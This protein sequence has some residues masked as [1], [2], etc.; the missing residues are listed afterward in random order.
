MEHHNTDHTDIIEFFDRYQ[1]ALLARDEQ[2]IAQMYAVPS[3]ILFPGQAIPV[4]DAEQTEAF[5]ASNWEQYEGLD[6]VERE[7]TVMGEG[8]VGVCGPTS[9]G[10]TGRIGGSASATSS[11]RARPA[12]RSPSS[13]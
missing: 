2:A 11:S 6:S 1:E 9:A 4:T 13:P 5:F 8:P 7:I 3:L 10:P 12:T